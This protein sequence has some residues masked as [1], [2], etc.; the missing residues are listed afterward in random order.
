MLKFRVSIFLLLVISTSVISA[1]LSTIEEQQVDFDVFNTAILKKEGRIDIHISEAQFKQELKELGETLRSEKSLLEQYKLFSSTL[2]KIECGHTQI[3]PNKEVLR[4]WLAERNTLPIDYY[5]IGKRLFVS[6]I[7]PRDR[8]SIHEGK[9]S[10]ERE[11]RISPESE[12]L[13]ID[14]L[15]IDSMMTCMGSFISSD[16]D[17]VEFKYHQAAQL[18]EFYR[19]LALPFEKDSIEVTYVTAG[20][21]A[22]QYFV[23]GT[24]PVFTM[25]TRIFKYSD[26][27]KENDSEYG[28]F[29]IIKAKYG[30]FRFKSFVSG[31]GKDYDEFL[32]SSF[33]KLSKQNIDKL[34][35]DLRGNTGGVMQYAFMKY[36]LGPDMEL[37]RYVVE[38]PSDKND[39][40]FVK[41]GKV[42]YVKHKRMSKKQ[43]RLIKQGRFNNGQ[44]KTAKVDDNL[45]FKGDVV[46]ITDE[47]TFSS[48]AMLACHLKTLANAKIVGR[49][50][51]GSFYIGNAG[52]LQ[53]KLP[54]SGFN[55]Y[56]NPNTFYSHLPLV[57]DPRAIKTPDIILNPPFL[58]NKEADAFYFKAATEIFK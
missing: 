40:K 43:Q 33:T 5:L 39:P 10:L 8:E 19:H 20:D 48:A 26:E 32:L 46:V 45:V 36:L 55:F 1:S 2:A 56:V 18:F 13:T 27:E 47:G 23:P 30:Y 52:T 25:N 38:K 53:V 12:I 21:T 6:K 44:I 50:A 35:V 7:D 22:Q 11:K 51:G 9:N 14:G 17:L 42:E 34:V 3:Y 57:D 24:A 54:K 28:D 29:K 16:E 15:T 41:K 4:E 37:G 49:T 58:S 31:Y